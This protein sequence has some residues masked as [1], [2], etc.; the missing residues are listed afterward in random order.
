M[1]STFQALPQRALV[2]L[3]SIMLL[4]AAA[5]AQRVHGSFQR[6]LTVSG[7]A[8]IE[9]VTGSGRIEV[10]QGAAG[11]VEISARLQADDSW[12]WRR[13]PLSAEERVRRIEAAPPIEQKGSTVR[14]GHITDDD[15][16]DGVSISYT[17]TLPPGASLKAKT[18]SGSQEIDGVD[19]NIEASSG[20]GSLTIRRSGSLRASTGSGSITADRIGG[21]LHANSGS[22]SIHAAGVTGA[23]TAKTGSGGIDV[24][25][26]GS[27]EVDVSSSSGS[28][29]LQG[30]RGGVRA[31]T[32][33]GGLTIQGELSGD[34]RLSTASGQLTVDLPPSQRFDL[35][36][37]TTSGRIDVDFPV[38]VTGTIGRRSLRGAVQGGGPLLHVR[39]ASGGI[40]IR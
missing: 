4:P 27:G 20:S 16:R 29:R 32:S 14:I 26:T 3:L 40:S 15:L 7:P 2:A 17:L 33:S 1:T 28:V 35:D 34:W 19:G 5:V 23:I 31:S 30:V 25:Q 21:A 9:V 18:G 36:A 11:R 6:T 24:T 13:S 8:D 12:G 39:T 37:N 38:T 10:R 22:G